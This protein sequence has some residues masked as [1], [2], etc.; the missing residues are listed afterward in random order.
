MQACLPVKEPE[1]REKQKRQNLQ[2]LG[3]VQEVRAVAFLWFPGQPTLPSPTSS[4]RG[5]ANCHGKQR[6]VPSKQSISGPR[7]RGNSNSFS[8]VLCHHTGPLQWSFWKPR[9]GGPR[10][11][12]KWWGRPAHCSVILPR[13]HC[14]GSHPSGRPPPAHAEPLRN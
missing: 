3:R 2:K 13:S 14:P 11:T 10:T 12:G 6:L 1:K 8:L 4:T 9:T 7:A 5:G